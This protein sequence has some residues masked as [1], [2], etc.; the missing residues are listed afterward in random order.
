M[1]EIGQE[2][3]RFLGG[4]SFLASPFKLKARLIALEFGFTGTPLIV[5]C[6]HLGGR[7]LQ[8]GTHDNRVLGQLFLRQPAQ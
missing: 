3:Q 4:K 1:R 5:L 8:D 7:P 6:D 2:N